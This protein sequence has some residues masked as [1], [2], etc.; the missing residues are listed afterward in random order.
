MNIVDIENEIAVS[1]IPPYFP[2]TPPNK[3][4]TTPL[5]SAKSINSIHDIKDKT[6]SRSPR[7]SIKKMTSTNNMNNPQITNNN[8]MN[9]PKM[10]S[11]NTPSISSNTVHDNISQ[12]KDYQNLDRQYNELILNNIALNNNFQQLEFELQ[13]KECQIKDQ[14]EKI[15]NYEK[16]LKHM[17]S[18]YNKNK[19]LFTQELTYYKELISDQQVRIEK[20]NHENDL[21]SHQEYIPLHQPAETPQIPND[22]KYNRLLKDYKVL[23]RNFEIEQN[24]K[25]VLIDQVEHLTKESE[26]NKINQEEIFHHL[27]NDDHST[28]DEVMNIGNSQMLSCLVDDLQHEKL[29]SSSP[30]KSSNYTT[31]E[32]VEVSNNFQFPPATN[33]ISTHNILDP[34][35]QQQFPPSPD[36]QSKS[37]KRQSLPLKLKSANPTP[38]IEEDNFVLSPLKLTNTSSS[39]LDIDTSTASKSHH[40]RYS[41][42]KPTHS[43]YNSHDIVPIKVE[44]EPLQNIRSISVP[45]KDHNNYDSFLEQAKFKPIEEEHEPKAADD[46]PMD[47]NTSRSVRNSAFFALNGEYN[48]SPSNRNSL[49]TLNTNSS[50]KRSSLILE[51]NNGGMNDVTK[52]EIMKLKFELQSLKLHNEKLLSY[53]GFE[54]QKQ[55][56]NIKKLSSKQSLSNDIEAPSPKR[57]QQRDRKMEYSDAKLIEKSRE[58]LIHKK[59]V[60]RSVSINPILS[61]KYGF[62]S[63]RNND[64]HTIDGSKQQIGIGFTPTINQEFLFPT[65]RN[66]EEEED[67]YL[68][69]S[70][71][72]NSIED[73]KLK[74][75]D[76]EDD[77]GFLKHNKRFNQ[78]LF[79]SGI[80]S[81]LNYEEIGDG[82]SFDESSNDTSF[83]LQHPKKFKSQIFYPMENKDSET[84]Y[85]DTS[86]SVSEE[87]SDWQDELS[88]DQGMIN[89][90]RYMIFGYPPQSRS[91]SNKDKHIRKNTQMVD[92]NLKYKFLSI[93]FGIML[94]GIRCS[95][96]QH[97]RS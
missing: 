88:N 8:N 72:I 15:A 45:E 21:L 50:S 84:D 54:L 18:D 66:N 14:M 64:R 68:F 60:L 81:Y 44:F 32:S 47:R 59:R 31:D 70:E 62:T 56:K 33:S 4:S 67:N 35:Q 63:K 57:K 29:E 9:T 97:N 91:K 83:D 61:K 95:N 78:R 82:Y 41:L 96:Y 1:I 39:F 49:L 75:N 27:I 12:T 79:S 2:S 36:P 43:R 58:M 34:L 40:K 37:K 80:E 53:I 11:N 73:E 17:E 42:S 28:D 6:P 69:S 52:Q 85:N 13:S 20:L 19:D 76:D 77:Y 16:I 23:Q 5:G 3:T 92:D 22:E 94:I 51:P 25:I 38:I 48:E 65:Q 10:T 90:F 71:F 87:D 24:S 46:S 26:M 7:R 74:H 89:R 30:I 55:K 86:N 93:A